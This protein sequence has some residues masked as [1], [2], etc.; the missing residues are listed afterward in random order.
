MTHKEKIENI[1]TFFTTYND[2]IIYIT[3]ALTIGYFYFRNKIDFKYLLDFFVILFTLLVLYIF[4]APHRMY[5]LT[6]GIVG[7]FR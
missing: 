1:A 4:I 7:V 3:L 6:Y 2:I 5:G